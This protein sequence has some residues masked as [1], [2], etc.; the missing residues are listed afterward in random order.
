MDSFIA[1][2]KAVIG[3]HHGLLLLALSWAACLVGHPLAGIV[4]AIYVAAI[5]ARKEYTEGRSRGF[6]MKNWKTYKHV[7]WWDWVTPNV[8]A[9]ISTWFMWRLPEIQGMMK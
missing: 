2:L 5:Y 4:V 3:M 1:R 7:E 9:V 6:R 8:L